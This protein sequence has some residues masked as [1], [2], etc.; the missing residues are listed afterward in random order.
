MTLALPTLPALESEI[1]ADLEAVE[2]LLRDVVAS[3]YPMLQEAS[4]FLIDAGGKRFRPILVLLSGRFGPDA[5]ARL[6]H[7]AAAIELTHLATLYHDDV[8]DGTQLRRGVETAHHRYGSAQAILVGDFL[9]ARASRLSAPLGAAV[10]ERLADTIGDLVTGQVVETELYSGKDDSIPTIAEH[11]EVIRLKTA[12]LIATSCHLGALLGGA[13]AEVRE[14][15]TSYGQAVG[16]AFQ[17]SDDLLDLVGD[18]GATGK[19]PGT[20]LRAGVWTLAPLHTLTTDHADANAFRSAIADQ[21][22][23]TAIA[24]LERNGSLDRAR[25]TVRAERDRALSALEGLP[26][27]DA[28]EALRWLAESLDDRTL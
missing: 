26:A 19:E 22:I 23:T 13:T 9:F 21:E 27:G 1:R 20:D 2:S 5:D 18:A 16:M 3:P 11:L 28:R 17:L 4:R 25:A 8:M 15:I 6:T 14:A 10:S 12:T 7:C 24:I